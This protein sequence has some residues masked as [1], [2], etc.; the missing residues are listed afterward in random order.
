MNEDSDADLMRQVENCLS[1]NNSQGLKGEEL[2][3]YWEFKNEFWIHNEHHYNHPCEILRRL[4]RKFCKK[5]KRFAQKQRMFA[6][7]SLLYVSRYFA[8]V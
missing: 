6:A 5:K 4:G 2:L 8:V 1:Q 7:S 3:F